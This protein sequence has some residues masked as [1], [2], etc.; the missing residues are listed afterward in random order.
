VVK[1]VAKFLRE[2]ASYLKQMPDAFRKAAYRISDE[3]AER[4]VTMHDTRVRKALG[5]ETDLTRR[6]AG[7]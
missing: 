3:T 6:A 4:I 7:Y 2:H 1:D 5:L